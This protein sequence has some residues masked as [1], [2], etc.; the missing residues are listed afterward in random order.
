[1]ET[2]NFAKILLKTSFCCM[3]SDGDIDKR[4][5]NQIKS[6]CDNSELFINLNLENEINTYINELNKEGKTFISNYFDQ[7][8]NALL[9]EEEALSIIDF[10]VKTIFAD[11]KVE[12]S[13]IKFF[14]AIR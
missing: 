3:A 9:N 5:I 2:N 14:K 13:E 4:E 7:L 8:K 10:S 1:M 12:Y 6:L 11:E